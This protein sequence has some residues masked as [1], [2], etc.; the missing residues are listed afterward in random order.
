MPK[1]YKFPKTP[2]LRSSKVIDDDE[3]I[4][5]DE[6]NKLATGRRVIIQEKL[7]GTSVGVHFE[8]KWQP[9]LQKRSGLITNHEKT[10]YNLFRSWIQKRLD[11]L[12]DICKTRYCL[13][14][15]WL[16]FR[17]SVAYNALPDFFISY[18]L[19]EKNT[20]KFLS[21][22]KFEKIINGQLSIVPILWQGKLEDLPDV[23]TLITKSPYGDELMEGL[24][25]RFEAAG[26]VQA[27]CKLRRKTFTPGRKDF[28]TKPEKNM[29]KI[30]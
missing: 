20:D 23:T 25:M 12:W 21:H 26:Y 24:Y 28:F 8:Q 27:R 5:W 19:L 7:D 15:E 29:L 30:E 22:R 10:Q 1:F 3:I 6:F 17:H 9:I 4:G 18:D 14:G 2:H 16:M 13:F 11:L